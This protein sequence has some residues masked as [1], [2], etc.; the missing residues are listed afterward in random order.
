VVD[1]S[2]AAAKAAIGARSYNQLVERQ[3]ELVG[4]HHM[5][6]AASST[7]DWESRFLG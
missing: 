4:Y 7:R 1:P 5:L 3:V 2:D 6:P